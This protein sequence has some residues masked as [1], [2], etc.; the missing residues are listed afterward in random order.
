MSGRRPGGR[1]R[2]A[3]Y[4]A[5]GKLPRVRERAAARVLLD[6]HAFLWWVGD[7]PRLSDTARRT[8]IASDSELFLSTASAWEIAI[9]VGLGRLTFKVELERFIADHLQ[10]NRITPL[11]ITLEHALYVRHLPDHHRDPFDRLLVAQSILEDLP[12]V[13]GDRTLARYDIEV[14]W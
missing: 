5:P 12:I 8:L 4:P 11:P 13:T 3:R 9:K 14:V 7:D 10:A 2:V 1:G 6:T